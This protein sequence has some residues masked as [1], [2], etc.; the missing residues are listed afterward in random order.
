MLHHQ[1]MLLV[2]ALKV[3]QPGY[4]GPAS[5]EESLDGEI[6]IRLEDRLPPPPPIELS[7]Q[8]LRTG[9]RAASLRAPSATGAGSEAE[10]AAP[11]LLSLASADYAQITNPASPGEDSSP[12]P[13][14]RRPSLTGMTPDSPKVMSHRRS[15]RGRPEQSWTGLD[16]LLEGQ[17]A[18][19]PEAADAADTRA[20]PGAPVTLEGLVT[21]GPP[22]PRGTP[23]A[24]RLQLEKRNT[25]GGA[26]GIEER[27]GE[28]ECTGTAEELPCEPTAGA[29]GAE[30]NAGS[31]VRELGVRF[32]ADPST[33]RGSN[34]SASSWD[35]GTGPP[36]WMGN[37]TADAQSAAPERVDAVSEADA[38]VRRVGGLAPVDAEVAAASPGLSERHL[39]IVDAA[40]EASG[41]LTSLEDILSSPAALPLLRDIAMAVTAVLVRAPPS[42]QR[43]AKFS[44]VVG[45]PT[46]SLLISLGGDP[47]LP[48]RL[49]V[50][51]AFNSATA[52]AA[53]DPASKRL[54]SSKGCSGG[55]GAAS[56]G[57]KRS[58]RCLRR[59]C[60]AYSHSRRGHRCWWSAVGGPSAGSA[61]GGCGG[62]GAGACGYGEIPS[63]VQRR[64][65]RGGAGGLGAGA[66]PAMHSHC[67]RCCVS[68]SQRR[69]PTGS[70]GSISLHASCRTRLGSSELRLSLLPRARTGARSA[71][72]PRLRSG[73]A[74]RI[75]PHQSRCD[76]DLRRA[77]RMRRAMA[78][79]SAETDEGDPA[80][81]ACAI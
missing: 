16:T 43:A 81:V 42:L 76:C 39:T 27:R 73:R 54:Q 46:R 26:N 60:R 58:A 21:P 31:V 22:A 68:L 53:P 7:F 38:G 59:W 10:G 67:T 78:Q 48:G 65:V 47:R 49:R 41:G 69:V 17:V 18:L 51:G 35:S 19:P 2:P 33:S 61:G 62:A 77:E 80:L 12:W 1:V 6:S 74:T 57:G 4:G 70:D 8:P 34:S 20:A 56:T 72:A 11:S 14:Q 44:H 5:L 64:A 50:A 3:E 66:M 9:S 52:T 32:L 71:G 15:F 55:N 25:F 79:R 45:Q 75:G 30:A 37:D 40:R 13:P 29:S 28:E 63:G 24:R 23:R 36:R